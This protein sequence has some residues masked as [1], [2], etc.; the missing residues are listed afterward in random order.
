LAE[1]DV[2]L[3]LARRLRQE[4]TTRGVTTLLIRD[5]DFTLTPDQRANLANTAHPAIYICLHATSQGSGVRLY[6][7]MVPAV[8]QARGPFLDWDT[9]Q[10]AFLTGSQAATANVSAELT[11]RQVPVRVL[12]APLRPLNNVITAAVGVEVAPSAE[13]I[14]SLT[15]P[16]YQDLIAASVASGVA[17]MRDKLEGGR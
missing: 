8:G 17:D 3:A 1:K 16:A 14:S 9:A 4:L 10:S 12:V 13:G 2:T 5:G 6:T 15:L 7:A 11:Q